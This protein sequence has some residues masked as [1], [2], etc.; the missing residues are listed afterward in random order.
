MEEV[1]EM[2]SERPKDLDVHAASPVRPTAGPVQAA[3]SASETRRAWS[4]RSLFYMKAGV[5]LATTVALIPILAYQSVLGA[6]VYVGFLVAV[7]VL[8]L[9]AFAY[10][11]RREHFGQGAR[12]LA[13]RIGGLVLLTAL[14]YLASKGL[15]DT[16]G[17]L[18]FWISL[19]AI[20]V[21][22]TA[23]AAML[24]LRPGQSSDSFCPFV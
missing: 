3:A 10:G 6:Q 12:G 18:V 5:L 2:W 19:T 22:H 15:S 8:G 7:H 11:L 23:G 20:W 1:L 24:H 21:L 4:D 14:L 9:A 17:S 13:I 16:F